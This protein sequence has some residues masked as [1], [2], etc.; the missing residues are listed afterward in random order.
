MLIHTILK[1]IIKAND[2]YFQSILR[3][4]NFLK[5]F[6]AFI[7]ALLKLNLK[8]IIFVLCQA[9]FKTILV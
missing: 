1:Q 5:L 7:N 4:M 3:A 9:S 6:R 2:F 8:I